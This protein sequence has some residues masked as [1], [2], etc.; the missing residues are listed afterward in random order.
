MKLTSILLCL[1]LLG[2]RASDQDDG[3]VIK[4]PVVFHVLWV[5]SSQY[6]SKEKILSDLADAN[7]D[8]Q[9]AN[10]DL[11]TAFPD[12]RQIAGNAKVQFY[13]QGDVQYV[14]ISDWGTF[15]RSWDN[16]SYLHGLS[17]VV[18][19]RHVMNVYTCKIKYHFHAP[20]GLSPVKDT[21]GGQTADDAVNI[22]YTQFGIHSRI[23][24]HE[25]G[26]W[27]GLYHTF[28]SD[29]VNT[30]HITDI[31]LQPGPTDGNARACPQ[32]VAEEQ[33]SNT[34][35]FAHTNY[36]NFMDYSGCRSM[37]SVQQVAR[38]RYVVMNFR[39]LIWQSSAN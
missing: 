20:E 13:L 17:P 18:D 28:D 19:P 34:P 36:N 32:T 14:H 25:A 39:P 31:P 9:M 37:F 6:I 16:T 30:D 10:A 27:L 15:R 33:P 1:S 5:D 22:H 29:Q 23:L 21:I 24:T 26:H 7:K 12:F 3:R 35:G 2:T 11:A 8:F 38:I 4:I